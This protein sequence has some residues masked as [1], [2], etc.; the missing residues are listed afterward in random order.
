MAYEGNM[1]LPARCQNGAHDVQVTAKVAAR[2]AYRKSVH[3][4]MQGTPATH[5]RYL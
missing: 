4:P 3:A 1:L 5:P 2:V